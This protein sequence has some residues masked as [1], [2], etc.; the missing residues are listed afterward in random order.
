MEARSAGLIALYKSTLPKK[1]DLSPTPVT[2]AKELPPD[3]PFAAVWSNVAGR[4]I[5]PISNFAW[6]MNKNSGSL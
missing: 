2:L 5:V 3:H 4:T 6:Q 1:E